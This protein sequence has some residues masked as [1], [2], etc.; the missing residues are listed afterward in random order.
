M[1]QEKA[2]SAQQVGDQHEVREET[3]R[4]NLDGA[5]IVVGFVEGQRLPILL[6]GLELLVAF[7]NGEKSRTILGRSI[8][9]LNLRYRSLSALRAHFP[10]APVSKMERRRARRL[11][12]GRANPADRAMK[13]STLTRAQVRL[14]GSTA[15]EFRRE[16]M[17]AGHIQDHLVAHRGIPI[18]VRLVSWGGDPKTTD[19]ADVV[20]RMGLYEDGE[21]ECFIVFG[22]YDRQLGANAIFATV[23]ESNSSGSPT[24]QWTKEEQRTAIEHALDQINQQQAMFNAD[25]QLPN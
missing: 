24:L 22:G 17:A 13:T 11:L 19:F 21:G 3:T 5:D 12:T 1:K 6:K 10:D 20:A 4:P 25:G 9:C 8:R 16:M 2:E 23:H 18:T 7:A 14:A 15:Q